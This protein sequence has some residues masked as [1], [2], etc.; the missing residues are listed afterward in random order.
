V[1]T[2]ELARV[3]PHAELRGVTILVE[4][5]PVN[6]SNVI[7][8]L[9]EAVAIVQQIASPAVQTMIDTHNA[10]DEKEEHASLI[11]KYR[12]FIRHVH[13]NE[14]DGR[15]P[16]M[17]QYDFQSVLQALGEIRYPGWISL[18]VF[19]FSRDAE[20]VAE[21]ARRHLEGASL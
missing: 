6:Q 8:S 17:G 9:A 3:A 1:F 21:R 14:L 12:E 13:V 19:D 2:Q 10:V 15:E 11:R 16:G 7:N 5:L 18:E 4:A 20:E